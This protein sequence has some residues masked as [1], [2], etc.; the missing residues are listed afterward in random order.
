MQKKWLQ[1]NGTV[2]SAHPVASAVGIDILKQGG[3]A[4]DA[5]VA[6]GFALAVCLPSAG[7]IG[8]GGF[9]VLRWADGS[10][11]SLD[12]REK[13]PFAAHSDMFLDSAKNVIE[14]LS[15]YHSLSAG[16]PGSVDGLLKIHEKYGILKL[17][18]VIQP[19]IDLA[20]NGFAIT[21]KQAADL[22]RNDALFR[23]QNKGKDIA[24]VSDTLWEEGDL[25]IQ[26]ELAQTLL[27][28]KLEGR[29][30]FYE[31]S[32]ADMIVN[33]MTNTNGIITH[34]DLKE[35]NSVWRNVISSK[36][37]EYTITSMAPPSSGGVAL[38]QL[39]LMSE[40]FPIS[41]WGWN[42][43]ETTHLTA[44][45]AK[46]VYAD[47]AEYLGDNDFVKVPVEKLINREYNINRINALNLLQATPSSE[48]KAGNFE[49]AES[50]ETTHYSIVDKFGNA[51]AITTTLNHSYGCGIVVG[52]GGFLLNNEMDDFSVK[53][54]VPNSYG[55]LGSSANSIEAGKRMLS[56]MTPT[57]VEKNGRL[58]LVLGSPG[59]STIITSVYQTIMNIVEHNMSVQEAVAAKRFHHQWQPDILYY[60]AGAFSLETI[61]LLQ[62]MGYQLKERTPFG[63]VDAILITPDTIAVGG[64]DPRGDDVSM[65]Y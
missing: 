57:I 9:M 42:T 24:F 50:E 22:N 28:I 8:G 4:A 39:M 45:A 65:W 61:K 2:V 54:G 51:I 25:L 7:N 46:R 38:I 13:A 31:G 29:A 41:E 5:A 36:Y 11:N 3:N 56:S 23:N 35:Y 53:S 32:V 19:A 47:R 14:D 58:F 48:I 44:E 49:N 64:A 12:F 62:Q 63:R 18:T 26:K 30:G 52:G 33:E 34:N 21:A 37:K 10:Y 16:V 27:K 60:E 17:E 1:N 6:V 59:G 15:L 20:Y 55:L 43:L 40:K